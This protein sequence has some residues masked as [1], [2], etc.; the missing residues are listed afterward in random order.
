LIT[1]ISS[2]D[3]AQHWKSS[4]LIVLRSIVLLVLFLTLVVGYKSA[5]AFFMH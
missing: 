5:V 3:W 4:W 1:Y 2:K